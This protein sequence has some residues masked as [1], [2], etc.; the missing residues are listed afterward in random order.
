LELTEEIFA[1]G[2][3]DISAKIID[4]VDK[5]SIE[6][7]GAGIDGVLAEIDLA[8]FSDSI[9]LFHCETEWVDA[10]MAVAARFQ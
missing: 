8:E 4:S 5:R 3:C 10:L 7:G 6:E 9:E 1:P 2:S